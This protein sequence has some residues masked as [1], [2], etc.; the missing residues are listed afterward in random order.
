M[1]NRGVHEKDFAT[2]STSFLTK[3]SVLTQ[4]LDEHKPTVFNPDEA[5]GVIL[6]QSSF[7]HVDLLSQINSYLRINDFMTIG[8]FIKA[9]KH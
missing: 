2:S 4:E 7:Q 9:F 8:S 3:G 6:D 1:I 5:Q